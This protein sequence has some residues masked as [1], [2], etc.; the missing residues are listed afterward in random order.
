MNVTIPKSDES[1]LYIERL[2]VH[3]M[4]EMACNGADVFAPMLTDMF[5]DWLDK[6]HLDSVG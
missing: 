6:G 5:R 2:I 4:V 3:V 1:L